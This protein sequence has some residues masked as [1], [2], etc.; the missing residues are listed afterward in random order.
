MRVADDS[1]RD[2]LRGAISAAR[3][4]VAIAALTRAAAAAPSRSALLS[5]L[6]LATGVLRPPARAVARPA[7]V[8]C[9][10]AP[11]RGGPGHIAGAAD[12]S[13][14]GLRLASGV[15]LVSP[16]AIAV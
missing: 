2:G 14:V 16:A 6:P 13:P 15:G 12:G 7:Q 10:R 11:P 5:G 1:Q 9:A 3:M 4:P 8:T